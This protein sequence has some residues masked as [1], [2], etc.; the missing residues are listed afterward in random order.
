MNGF[1]SVL[2]KEQEERAP[3]KWAFKLSI[4]SS[5]PYFKGHF[6]DFHLL[7]AV[8][9]VDIV[10]LLASGL[11][12]KSVFIT[13]ISRTK[14]TSPLLPEEEAVFTLDLSRA[15]VISFKVDASGHECAKGFLRYSE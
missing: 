3:G 8:A 11:L 15:G 14:F 2:I 1:D 6:P 13:S 9:T 10:T 5:S 7:P 12:G 4:P